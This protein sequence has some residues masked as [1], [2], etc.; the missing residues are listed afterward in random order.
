MHPWS[1][2]YEKA[3]TA[4][5][6]SV[7]VARVEVPAGARMPEHDHIGSDVVVMPQVGAGEI[8]SNIR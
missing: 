4:A 1:C 6:L 5:L 8:S 2:R 7:G 3:M